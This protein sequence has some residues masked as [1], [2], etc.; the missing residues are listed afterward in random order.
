M[1][2]P[3]VQNNGALQ[4]LSFKK[5]HWQTRE[6][7]LHSHTRVFRGYKDGFVVLIN[8]INY[9][10]EGGV[11]EHMQAWHSVNIRSNLL[12]F[13]QAAPVLER[14][15]RSRQGNKKSRYIRNVVMIWKDKKKKK[16]IIPFQVKNSIMPDVL[17]QSPQKNE[18]RNKWRKNPPKG[19]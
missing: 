19:E 16:N 5:K 8:F 6:E 12:C 3:A 14:S 17:L 9:K 4:H 13:P 2:P 18:W 11:I 15:K 1:S 7:G 10:G